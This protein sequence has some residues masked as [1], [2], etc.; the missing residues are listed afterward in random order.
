MSNKRHQDHSKGKDRERE[1]QRGG[2]LLHVMEHEKGKLTRGKASKQAS[3]AEQARREADGQ[4]KKEQGE[5]RQKRRRKEQTSKEEQGK[6]AEEEGKKS[7]NRRKARER[8]LESG[9]SSQVALE[10]LGQLHVLANVLAQPLQSETAHDEPQLEGT[11]AAPQ[12]DLP[13]LVVGDHTREVVAQ[14]HRGGGQR[15]HQ[16]AALPDPGKPQPCTVSVD[17]TQEKK[18]QTNQGG[19]KTDHRA[20][21]SKLVI[22]HL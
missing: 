12:G 4:E 21:T 5:S 10:A 8:H 19:N 13:V 20:D 6:Q 16:Q 14:V 7:K 3:K 11:E 15:V 9:I 2:I 1:S 17:A 18:K 22:I